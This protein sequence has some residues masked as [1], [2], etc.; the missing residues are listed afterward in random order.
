MVGAAAIVAGL[1]YA[2]VTLVDPFDTLPLSPKLDRAPVATN[3]R[4]SFPAL[5]RSEAFDSALFGTST[6]RLLR[7]AALNPLFDV[8]LVNLSMNDATAYEMTR[9]MGVFS[10]AHAAPKL[11]RVGLDTR[12]CVTG[13]QWQL[14]TVRAFPEWMYGPNRWA[15][16][17]EMYNLHAIE[18]AGR[19][20]GIVTG[21]K[22]VVYGRDGYTS[23]VPPDSAYDPV[24]VA[25]NLTSSGPNIPEGTRSGP[26][27]GWRFPTLELLRDALAALPDGTRKL[28]F[29]VPYH[30]NL[31][32]PDGSAGAMLWNECKRR[33]TDLARA[34]PNT[35]AVDFMLPSPITERDDHYWDPLHYRVGIA[36]RLASGLAG[37]DRGEASPD[38]RILWH[39]VRR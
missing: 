20:F 31:L 5:A 8:R 17:A 32:S 27:E 22:A 23:F 19:Q 10:K 3:A 21:I 1:I 14:L 18:T 13:D 16:Y 38:Y 34:I 15:G 25:A 39:Q 35:V 2:F 36:D 7:P 11:A 9:M 4:F 30:R 6:S 24:R 37:A 33:V 26:S 29:F 12:W 28:L